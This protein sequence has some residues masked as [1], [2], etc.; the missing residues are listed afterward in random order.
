MPTAVQ[1]RILSILQ[2]GLAGRTYTVK[3]GDSLYK[4]AAQ[5]LGNGNRWGEIHEL[6]KHVIGNNPRLI[7][8]GMVLKLPGNAA[9]PAPGGWMGGLR[10]PAQAL[11]DGGAFSLSRMGEAP[12]PSACSHTIRQ[13]AAC[14]VLF[15]P[16]TKC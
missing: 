8:V 2:R 12:R 14:K 6:N 16:T 3:S 5:T 1:N 13:S 10:S 9:S 11:K 7:R 4:I 15:T